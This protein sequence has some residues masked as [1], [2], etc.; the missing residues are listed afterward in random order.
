L[1]DHLCI[2][3]NP[4]GNR[5]L[6]TFRQKA[7][8]ARTRSVQVQTQLSITSAGA[9]L[10]AALRG[11]GLVRVLSYQVAEHLAG[12]HLRRV[13][14][15]FEP[16]AVPVNMI[17]RPNPRRWSPVRGFVDHAVPILRRELTRTAAIVDRLP[18]PQD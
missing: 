9:A 3:L 14:T 1:S 2:G 4:D 16:E 18:V 6:W 8:S 7:G 5:E 15:P 17:F 11:K 12:D 13:L 10:D